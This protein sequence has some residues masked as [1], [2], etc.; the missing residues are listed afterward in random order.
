MLTSSETDNTEFY[1]FEFGGILMIS[2][3]KS[4][5][6]ALAVLL[7]VEVQR[8]LD[9]T[10]PTVQGILTMK[11]GKVVFPCQILWAFTTP[12]KPTEAVITVKHWRGPAREKTC[13]TWFLN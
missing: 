13:P 8:R 1:L 6:S 10:R 9:W 12:M 11:A 4:H 2:C 7:I 3:R 5:A